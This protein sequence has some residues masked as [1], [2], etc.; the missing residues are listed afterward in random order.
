MKKLLITMCLVL[1]SCSNGDGQDEAVLDPL[2]Y[3]KEIA[4]LNLEF[5][6]E[7]YFKAIERGD[8]LS[9]DLFLKAGMSPNEEFNI[10]NGLMKFIPL[11]TSIRNKHHEVT[12]LLLKAGGDP[13]KLVTT[14][15]GIGQGYTPVTLATE[16]IDAKSLKLLLDN[17][18]DPSAA[19]SKEQFKSI[20]RNM[21]KLLGTPGYGGLSD[22]YEILEMLSKHEQDKENPDSDY[23]KMYTGMLENMNAM[24]INIC[25]N[26]DKVMRTKAEGSLGAQDKEY[27]LEKCKSM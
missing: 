14:G 27:I 18:G 11:D 12:L 25:A 1:S 16:L 13:N 3:R 23:L 17:K 6:T 5:T 20:L 4:A 26:K 19:F 22:S 24:F 21:S 8:T 9:V 7:D 10:G 15:D 2:H